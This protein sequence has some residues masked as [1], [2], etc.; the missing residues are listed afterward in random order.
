MLLLADGRFP[1]GG[2]VHSGGVES[3]VADGRVAD[4][5]S[6]ESFLLGRLW[7]VGLME[8]ALAAATAARIADAA[9]VDEVVEALLDLDAEAGA[10]LVAPPLREASR[11]L[12]R[13]I[14]RAAT[15]CW[16][17]VSLAML[18]EVLPAGA[19]FPV[20]LGA[21]SA[22]A[23]L[24][25][26]DA[27]RLA[28][29]HGIMV[30]AQAG[31][32]LLGLDPFAVAACCARLAAPGDAVVVEAVAAASRPGAELPARSSPVLDIAAVEH[33]AS[34]VRLFVT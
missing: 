20:A 10:R 11:R 22:A 34:D 14:A 28:V 6:L 9:G 7:T 26:T 27:A 3:A 18:A 24:D 1:G 29:H 25:P 30:P 31:V 21:V 33:R 15:R 23:G 32:R 16:P 12:G 17:N 19:H 5:A 2:N 8:A 4:E 13:Q